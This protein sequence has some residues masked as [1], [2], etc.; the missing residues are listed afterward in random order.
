M[1][2]EKIPILQAPIGGSAPPEL[3]AAVANAGAIGGIA[4]TGHSGEEAAEVIANTRALTDGLFFVNLLL[5]FEPECLPA[6]LDSDVPIVTF[7][8]GEGRD[9]IRQVKDRGK[10]CGVQVG[11]LTG[12]K[13]AVEQSADF[14]ICQGVEAGGRVQSTQPLSAL[15]KAV[16]DARLGVPVV[17]TGGI[18]SGQAIRDAMNLG[19]EG[20]MMG[21]RFL[22]TRESRSHELYKKRLLE[23]SAA[24][25]ALTLCFMDG[26]PYSAHRVL[27][28]QTLEDW[29]AAG[30]PP[31]GVRPGEGEAMAN[32]SD[33][34]PIT[35]YHMFQPLQS[36]VGRIEELAMYSGTGCGDI[37]DIPGAGELVQ[38]LWG[39]A[40]GA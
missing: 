37:H 25:T 7:S 15:L 12:A 4:L 33:G 3:A 20:V 30:C 18:A 23:A 31:P 29:E 24:D 2:G 6:I 17:A 28:N 11:T 26:W 22:A 16:S 13:R 5:A 34:E 32:T 36:Y 35:K 10:R 39:E 21:T 9:L 1:F 14:V 27:R 8:F 19:A 40:L 38:R